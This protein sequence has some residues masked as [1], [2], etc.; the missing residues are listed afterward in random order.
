[1]IMIIRTSPGII[2]MAMNLIA[3]TASPIIRRR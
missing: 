2:T 1:M 3:M